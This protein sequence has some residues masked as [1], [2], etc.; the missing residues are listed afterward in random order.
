MVKKMDKPIYYEENFVKIKEI[1]DGYV[2]IEKKI[3]FPKGKTTPK[4]EHSKLRKDDDCCY[5][6]RLSCNYGE[7]FR[8]C[9]YMVYGKYGWECTCQSHINVK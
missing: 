3:E 8:R 1:G 4:G 6:K 9:E 2:V 5:P 7:F